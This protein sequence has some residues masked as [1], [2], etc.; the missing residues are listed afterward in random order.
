MLSYLSLLIHHG[1]RRNAC[2]TLLGEVLVGLLPPFL[3]ACED[4]LWGSSSGSL[5][6]LLAQWAHG[7]W[8]GEGS[9]PC[10]VLASVWCEN[11]E[12]GS[13]GKGQARAASSTG[14]ASKPRRLQASGVPCCSAR[15]GGQPC[16]RH[17]FLLIQ[18]G[19]IPAVHTIEIYI[20]T[21]PRC[22]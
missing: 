18:E 3:R 1:G 19:M 17:G 11:G 16:L 20:A 4:A 12:L 22:L 21:E 13:P 15:G 10:A 14:R 7:R 5:N 8:P 6:S 9:V 2:F